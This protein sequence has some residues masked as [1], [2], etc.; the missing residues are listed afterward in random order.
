MF[1]CIPVDNSVLE[2]QRHCG[3]KSYQRHTQNYRFKSL[4]FHGTVIILFLLSA[5][6]PT[7]FGNEQL[8][9]RLFIGLGGWGRAICTSF[10][11]KLTLKVLTSKINHIALDGQM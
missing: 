8:S 6:H 2:I 9:E 4:V 1:Q 5:P 10:P 11:L 3:V 7:P